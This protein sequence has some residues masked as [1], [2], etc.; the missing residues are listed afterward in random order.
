LFD[1][2]WG[3]ETFDHLHALSCSTEGGVLRIFQATGY[4]LYK[5]PRP[6]SSDLLCSV[7]AS[8]SIFY[9]LGIIFVHIDILLSWS[10]Q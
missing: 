9:K 7:F 10:M 2:K 4:D 1:R 6:V 3:K 8:F 5:Q